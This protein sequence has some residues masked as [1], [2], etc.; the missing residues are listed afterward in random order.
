MYTNFEFWSSFL[1]SGNSNGNWYLLFLNIISY[2]FDDLPPS[3]YFLSS[4]AV[5]FVNFLDEVN[6]TLLSSRYRVID[7]FMSLYFY[8]VSFENSYKSLGK[9]SISSIIFFKSTVRFSG[10]SKIS[11]KESSILAC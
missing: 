1:G 3:N 5:S 8:K 2:I 10:Y 11:K 6:P 9:N 4:S 7:Q